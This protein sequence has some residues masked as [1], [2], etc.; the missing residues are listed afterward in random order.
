MQ[1]TSLSKD[2]VFKTATDCIILNITRHDSSEIIKNK[3]ITFP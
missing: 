2:T 1:D 3:S